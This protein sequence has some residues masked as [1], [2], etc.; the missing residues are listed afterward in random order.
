M[1]EN[2]E[3]ALKQVLK[4][5]GGFVNNPKDPGGMT[6]LGVTKAVW[7][8]YCG[9]VSTEAEMRALT[10]EVVAPLYKAQYWGQLG[11]NLPKGVDYL[12][13]DFAV[14]AGPSR[15]AKTLQTALGVVPD[16][17]IGPKSLEA[18]K[19]ADPVALIDKFTNAKEA[20]YKSLP[21]FETFG[22]GWMRRVIESADTA[23]AMI[24]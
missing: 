14:N 6:N 11:D 8:K 20:F 9:H 1:K 13:F 5:E 24:K 15:A 10:P 22:K 2:F 19:N 17:I 12:Y 18:I 7:D 16:G 21:T 3:F 4:H 23:K